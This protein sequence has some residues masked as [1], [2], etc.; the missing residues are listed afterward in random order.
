MQERNLV[1]F[2]KSR[3]T[4]GWRRWGCLDES[5]IAACA[6]HQLAGQARERAEAHLADCDFCLEQVA[7]LIRTQQAETPEPAPDWLLLRAKNL[8]QKE[9]RA[10][11]SALWHWGKFAAA[12]A[13]LALVAVVTLRRPL[14]GPTP[15]LR[16][17]PAA[18]LSHEPSRIAQSTPPAEPLRPPKVRGGQKTPLA[19]TVVFPPAGSTMSENEIEFHWVPVAGA[20]D[21]EVQLM[22]A[23][24]DLVW[25]Q[26]TAESVLRLPGKVKLEA[27]QKYFVSIRAY[28]AEG[29]SAQ[30]AP[31]AF[32]VAHR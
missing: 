4:K 29:K 12:A 2:F 20:L 18:R 15:A 13:C 31:V 30:S 14:T 19:L 11:G 26:K 21:Y 32:T 6:D 10:E 25:K 8:V 22:T 16:Q 5:Q 23:E 17:T 28:L 1:A 9:A 24:G 3:M 7:F 27:G